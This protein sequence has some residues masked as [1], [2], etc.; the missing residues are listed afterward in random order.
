TPPVVAAPAP[1]NLGVTAAAQAISPFASGEALPF[2]KGSRSFE[3]IE[4]PRKSALPPAT[5]FERPSAH[6]API[7]KF[8]PNAV[9]DLSGTVSAE[10]VSPIDLNALLPFRG[11]G[12]ASARPPP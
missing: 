9:M 4:K 6:P 1:Q 12:G 10:M 8:D 2:V 7:T 5:P 11:T 3:P